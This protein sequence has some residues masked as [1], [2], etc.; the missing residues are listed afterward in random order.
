MALLHQIQE[1][2]LN[3]E[4][5]I[6]PALLKFKFLAAKLGSEPLEDW[7][8]HEM[9][10]YPSKIEVPDYRLANLTY[11]GNFANSAYQYT[12]HPIPTSLIRQHTSE[13]W[14][15][16]KIREGMSAIDH[17]VNGATLTGKLTIDTSDM[18]LLLQGKIYEQM[19]VQSITATFP[20]TALLSIQ[21]TVRAKL[22]D[23]TLELEKRV[24]A[25][26]EIIVGTKE[27]TSEK[28]QVKVTQIFNQTVHGDMTNVASS[29]SD[30][31]VTVNVTKNDIDSLKAALNKIG[32]EASDADEL[33]K[34]AAD[35]QPDEPD[36]PFGI[37][38]RKWLA[39]KAGKGVDGVISV[40]G[41]VAKKE[42][43]EAFQEFYDKFGSSL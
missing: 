22:L 11:T 29:G 36:Q 13:G 25:S 41:K 2:L 30:A 33:A 8:E 34:I 40:G 15:V 35:E 32:F 28:E 3:E 6:A 9:E 16:H 7:V 5:G 37:K 42:L 23:L 14:V 43:T 38:A 19:V 21:S 12:N 10:G 39:S 1:T 20:V 31:T 4:K 24:P 27:S 18:V 17:I 26:A